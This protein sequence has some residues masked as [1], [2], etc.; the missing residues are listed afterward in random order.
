MAKLIKIKEKFDLCDI[1]RIKIPKTKRYT[2]PKKYVF[3][4][5]QSRLIIFTFLIPYKSLPKH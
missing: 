3:G 4:L 1:W 2:F 5:L